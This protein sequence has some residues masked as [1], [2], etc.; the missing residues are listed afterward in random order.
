M[1]KTLKYITTSDG[2]DIYQYN[3]TFFNP[4]FKGEKGFGKRTLKN[5]IR[6]SCLSIIEPYQV[7][8]ARDKEETV[9]FA[10][11]SRGGKR[12]SCSTRE[13]IILGPI[14]IRKDKRG[15]G[16]G[17]RLIHAVLNDLDI[18]YK[19]A[20]EF[21]HDGNIASIRSAEKN[22]Y[23]YVCKGVYQGLL[24]NVVTNDNGNLLIYKKSAD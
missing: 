21:I 9:G 15:L 18:R 5:S 2:L 19:N 14:V 4:F 24:K 11:V 17:T 23:L 10:V 16:Y 3:G 13:D 8:Y 1:N 12:L 7:Y 22:G 20:Y 6:M